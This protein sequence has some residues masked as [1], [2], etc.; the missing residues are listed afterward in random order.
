MR[1]LAP[2]HPTIVQRR[3]LSRLIIL[4]TGCKRL[5]LFLS[6]GS[7]LWHREFDA[8]LNAQKVRCV[9]KESVQIPDAIRIGGRASPCNA[10]NNFSRECLRGPVRAFETNS[11]AFAI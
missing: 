4:A 11:D 3:F 1:F 8:Q 7:E 5:Q 9:G 2:T 6:S 10:K